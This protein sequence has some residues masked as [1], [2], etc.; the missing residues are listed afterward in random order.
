MG[1]GVGEAVGP[2]IESRV[3]VVSDSDGFCAIVGETVMGNT[4]VEGGS[5]PCCGVGIASTGDGVDTILGVL[6]GLE[7]G[8]EGDIDGSNGE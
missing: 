4:A 8:L 6:L 2:G 7:L 3:G 5:E 1:P